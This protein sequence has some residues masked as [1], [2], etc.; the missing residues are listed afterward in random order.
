MF[1]GFA[2]IEGNQAVQGWA[3]I[4]DTIEV[5]RLPTGSQLSENGSFRLDE[6]SKWR[7]SFEP[8]GL[9]VEDDFSK[10]FIVERNSEHE[11]FWIKLR[12]NNFT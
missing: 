2:F 1:I 3:A 12:I 4:P 5:S 10:R 8:H 11:E 9:K 6:T 7:C